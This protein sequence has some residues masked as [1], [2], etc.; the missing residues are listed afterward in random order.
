MLACAAHSDCFGTE[1]PRE[2]DSFFSDHCARCHQ[3]ETVQGEFDVN[4][5]SWDLAN[6]QVQ[7]TWNRIAR[8]IDS[9]QMPPPEENQPT[10][11]QWMTV[12]AALQSRFKAAAES[13]PLTDLAIRRLNRREYRT[14]LESLFGIAVDVDRWLPDD[15]SLTTYDTREDQLSLSA[16]QIEAYMNAAN[17]AIDQVLD[18]YQPATVRVNR[19]TLMDLPSNK[20]LIRSKKRNTAT[21]DGALV[22]YAGGFPPPKYGSVK[23]VEDGR[24]RCR[25][26]VWPVESRGRCVS[27]FLRMGIDFRS[28]THKLIDVFDVFGDAQQPRIIEFE[29]KLKRGDSFVLEP[30][31][32]RNEQDWM[33]KVFP[34]TGIAIQWAEM[35]G[36]L[37]Q[38]YPTENQIAVFGNHPTVTMQPRRKVWIRDSNGTYEHELRSS[39]PLIDSE[40]IIRY[41]LPLAFRR[42]VDE[43]EAEPYVDLVLAQLRRGRSFEESVRT[44]IVAILCSPQFLLLPSEG[45]SDR[46]SYASRLSYLL[47]SGPPDEELRNFVEQIPADLDAKNLAKRFE[48]QVDRLIDGEAIDRFVAD[49]TDQWLHLA[50]IDATTPDQVLYPEFDP[51]LQYSMVKETRSFFRHVLRNDRPIHELIDCDYALLNQR[52]AEHYGVTGVF[53]HEPFQQVELD[54]G[55]I[56]GGVLTQASVLKVTADGTATSPIRRGVFVAERVLG[57]DLPPPPENIEAVEPDVRGSTSIRELLAMHSND[58]SCNRCHRIIDPLGF[59]LEPFDPIGQY[60]R[61]YRSRGGGALIAPSV[62]YRRGLNV[63]VDEKWADGRAFTGVPDLQAYLRTI[64][65]RIERNLVE[66]LLVYATGHEPGIGMNQAVDEILRGEYPDGIGLRTVIHRITKTD[67]FGY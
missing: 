24:Y 26:A 29:A 38:A 57:V 66:Q 19:V 47:T 43:V 64:R 7:S 31:L 11:A 27:V 20:E 52:M 9:D 32:P 25:I 12:K 34:R 60:R 58:S 33:R 45:R 56:R 1:L 5:L 51:L 37:D 4:D 48:E 8:A 53:G 41:F 30:I 23:A 62:E 65:P 50:E 17:N 36:P 63:V 39:Q 18:R 40:S 3:G 15:A 59:A 13:K 54:H 10:A 61:F 21:I 44:G 6:R 14:T 2:V 46:Y 16:A 67:P 35:E 28:S 55:G 42:P 49:F 22:K